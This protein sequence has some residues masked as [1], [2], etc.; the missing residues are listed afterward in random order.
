[1]LV[2]TKKTSNTQ[3]ELLAVSLITMLFFLKNYWSAYQVFI[4]PAYFIV[5]MKT[6]IKPTYTNVIALA[7]CNV[8]LFMDQYWWGETQLLQEFASTNPDGAKDY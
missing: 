8:A 5:C 2:N 4:L 1:M 6:I 3:R 7:F